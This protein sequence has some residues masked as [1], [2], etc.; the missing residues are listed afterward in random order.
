MLE[1]SHAY[2]QRCQITLHGGRTITLEEIR[3]R[4]TYTGLLEGVP[5]TEFNDDIVREAVEAARETCSKGTEPF[6]IEPTRRDNVRSPGDKSD[7]RMGDRTPEWLP[8]V[9][10]IGMFKSTTPAKNKEMDA[11]SL[12][13]VWFQDD[14]T[15]VIGEEIIRSIKAIEWDSVAHDYA[16]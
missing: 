10:C 8:M 2:D 5:N 14:F 1:Y 15:P 3:L 9:R 4:Q 12:T 13:I 16:Y 11:S 6:L 7:G